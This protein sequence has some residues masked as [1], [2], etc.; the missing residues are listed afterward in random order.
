[1]FQFSLFSSFIPYLTIA[2]MYVLYL[3]VYTYNK[4]NAENEPVET[5]EAA[6]NT[7]SWQPL[8]SQK[9]MQVSPDQF[10]ADDAPIAFTTDPEPVPLPAAFR[11]LP[12]PSGEIPFTGCLCFNLFSRPPPAIS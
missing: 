5:E 11:K 3:G 9:T 1:M 6:E 4:L 7:V 8:Q 10:L 2:V 12:E